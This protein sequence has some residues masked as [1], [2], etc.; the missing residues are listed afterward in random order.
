MMGAWQE[1]SGAAAGGSTRPGVSD[2][3]IASYM[4]TPMF[5]EEGGEQQES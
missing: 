4:C 3:P 5:V 1:R 2:S